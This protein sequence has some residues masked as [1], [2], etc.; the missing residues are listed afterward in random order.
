MKNLKAFK[1]H[2]LFAFFLMSLCLVVGTEAS[3]Q[4]SWNVVAIE[5]QTLSLSG[6]QVVRYGTND[7]F[8]E[9][10]VPAGTKCSNAVF[11]DPAPGAHKLCLV[12]QE[13]TPLSCWKVISAEH[14]RLN[15]SGTQTVRYGTTTNYIEKTVANGARCNSAT[16][17]GDPAPGKRKQ[18]SA[19]SGN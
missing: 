16:F 9:Q 17:G 4:C 10:S 13:D 7:S 19:C 2:G 18:C 11:G 3:A 8:V 1:M 14:Q 15:L 6:T 5:G 12:C